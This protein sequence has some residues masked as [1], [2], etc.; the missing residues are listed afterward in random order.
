[1]CKCETSIFWFEPYFNH[2]SD[3]EELNKSLPLDFQQSSSKRVEILTLF[4]GRLVVHQAFEVSSHPCGI[5]WSMDQEL[6]WNNC[7]AM[8]YTKADVHQQKSL[9][10]D[11]DPQR[12]WCSATVKLVNTKFSR[13]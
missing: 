12:V 8:D 9:L 5:R 6:H 11:Q 3:Y 4:R 7:V 2:F 10:N 13:T 1:M